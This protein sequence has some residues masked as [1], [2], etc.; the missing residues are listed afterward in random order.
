MNPPK[1]TPAPWFSVGQS[2]YALMDD[3]KR[4]GKRVNRFYAQVQRCGPG[5][6][7]AKECEA[8]ARLCAAVHDLYE[9]VAALAEW[10]LRVSARDGDD[11]LNGDAGDGRNGHDEIGTLGRRSIA[12]LAKVIGEPT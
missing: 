9:G 6:A 4:P 10:H 3:P 11:F 1:W 2:V 12:V 7:S 8:N 5:S